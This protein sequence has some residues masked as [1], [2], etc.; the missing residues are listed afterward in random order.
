MWKLKIINETR[1]CKPIVKDI[2]EKC[3]A[4]ELREITYKKNDYEMATKLIVVTFFH[5]M[6]SNY[7]AVCTTEI[8][9]IPWVGTPGNQRQLPSLARLV[10]QIYVS[11]SR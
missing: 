4:S 11:I 10:D 3:K 6:L 7:A 8:K 1:L 2:I 9:Q 5:F